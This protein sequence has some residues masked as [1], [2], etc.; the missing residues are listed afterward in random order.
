MYQIKQERGR[1]LPEHE[2]DQGEAGEEH[3]K[4]SYADIA[5]VLFSFLLCKNL[6]CF[7]KQKA[8]N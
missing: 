1:K 3:R 5:C 4:F 7:S 8:A 6:S 2:R